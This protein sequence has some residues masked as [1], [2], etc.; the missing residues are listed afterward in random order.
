MKPENFE[1]LLAHLCPEDREEAGRRYSV[2]HAKVALFLCLKGVSDPENDAHDA[3]DRAGEK[4]RKGYNIPDIRSFCIGI[5]KN[6]WHERLRELEREKVAF[7]NYQENI[8]DNRTEAEVER[9]MNLIKPCF[10]KL[11]ADDRELLIKYYQVPPGLDGARQRCKLAES[12]KLNIGA[13]R[14]RI[15]RL[16]RRLEDCVKGL[17]D[18]L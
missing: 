12:Y 11:P 5:A 2:L 4:I 1:A 14:I 13:L 9:I 10:E 18:K 8:H 16:R 3:L 15:S 6:I 17:S 7:E